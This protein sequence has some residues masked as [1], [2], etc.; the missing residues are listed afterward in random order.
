MRAAH[1][2]EARRLYE[3]RARIDRP[4]W[5]PWRDLPD[6]VRLVWT[7]AMFLASLAAS[8]SPPDAVAGNGTK[9]STQARTAPPRPIPPARE[10]YRAGS[11]PDPA[12]TLAAS[13]GIPAT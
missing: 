5:L 3:Q 8:P 7:E 10:R 11:D 12:G 9:A 2:I 6:R 13:L 1:E 4:G